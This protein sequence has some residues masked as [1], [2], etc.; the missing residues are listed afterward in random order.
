MSPE[1][2]IGFFS[3][4]LSDEQKA[5]LREL[6]VGLAKED[7][8]GTEAA[9]EVFLKLSFEVTRTAI[10]ELQSELSRQTLEEIAHD[11]SEEAHSLS[12]LLWNGEQL[13][14]FAE[15]LLD[16]HEGSPGPVS[17]LT[18][19]ELKNYLVASVDFYGSRRGL[20]SSHGPELVAEP[21]PVSLNLFEGE[22]EEEG[23][24][25]AHEPPAEESV[26]DSLEITT[27]AAF[28]E[29]TTSS[30]PEAG[31]PEPS[32]EEPEQSQAEPEQNQEPLKSAQENL[33]FLELSHVPL[34]PLEA[35]SQL[36]FKKK[37]LGYGKNSDGVMGYCGQ[38]TLSRFDD[39][40]LEASLECSNPL[41]FLS[42]TAARGTS[43][44]VTY[45]M[46]PA[47]FPQPGGHLTVETP[48]HKK[49]L[50]VSSLFPQSR[51]DFLSDRYVVALLLAPA[52]L[53]LLYFGFVYFYS[54]YG[55]VSQ[56]R[57][58]FPQA[59]AAALTSQGVAHFRAEGVG[60]Y[61]LEVVPASES[62]QLIWAA[63]LWLAP[64][65]STKFFRHLSRARRRSF[66]GLLAAALVL[67]SVGLLLTWN[68]QRRL[69][70]I[71][72][73]PDFAPLDL[74]GFLPWGLPLNLLIATY[75]FLSVHGV[76]DRKLGTREVRFLLP[77]I[78]SLAYLVICFLLIFGRS[79]LS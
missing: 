58:L 12:Q 16:W 63:V 22:D 19:E 24:L 30:S 37:Y 75:L 44:T 4:F 1:R 39:K 65:A 64:L 31:E 51:T 18:L 79:W 77:L 41:L 66:G 35:R 23:E 52:A 34:S 78:L 53:G 40:P 5:A 26:D 32:Q 49:I 72:E 14:P 6:E 20:V 9:L 38:L 47:A 29:S 3:P 71:L 50:S 43:A 13:S 2:A 61:Q 46:P 27:E 42:T 60:L 33:E 28:P 25:V 17:G 74:R 54:S 10:L 45:W 69:F 62:L 36:V 76:W 68:L 48:E 55:I 59:Y 67:P 11:E 21:Q 7:A 70:P 73:H 8:S 15:R 57:E 56:V